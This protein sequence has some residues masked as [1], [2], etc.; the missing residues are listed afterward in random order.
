MRLV[1]EV[2]LLFAVFGVGA[3]GATW[4]IKTRYAS[5]IRRQQELKAARMQ[6]RLEASQKPG[7]EPPKPWKY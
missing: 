2:V 6:G 7:L 1:A 3:A 4:A 5:A